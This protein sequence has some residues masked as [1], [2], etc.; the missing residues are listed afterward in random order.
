[1]RK[2][3]LS[4][5]QQ[6]PAWQLEGNSLPGRGQAGQAT[7]QACES[8]ACLGIIEACWRLGPKQHGLLAAEPALTIYL[9]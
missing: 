4:T 1:M 8:M 7:C 5:Q 2:K 6:P 3:D 9:P